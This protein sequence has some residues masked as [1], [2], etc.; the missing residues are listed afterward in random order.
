MVKQITDEKINHVPPHSSALRVSIFARAGWLAY[1]L[2]II[3]ASLYPFTGW[4][5][6]G[7]PLRSYLFAG[8]PRYWTGFDVAT[9]IIGYIPLGVLTTYALYP[10]IR[11][12]P[13]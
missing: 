9:N 3:Y 11:R 12:N 5:D 4:Q 8:M 1:V 7:L 13:D 2:L 6:L 10:R